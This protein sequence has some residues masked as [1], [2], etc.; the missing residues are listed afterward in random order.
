MSETVWV[1]N[2]KCCCRCGALLDYF[3]CILCT[4]CLE[5]AMYDAEQ[6]RFLDWYE[7]AEWPPTEDGV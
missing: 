7:D 3:E 4:D 6:E 1:M 5:N 2:S